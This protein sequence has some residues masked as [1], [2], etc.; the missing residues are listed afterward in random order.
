MKVSV[1]ILNWN[2]CSLLQQFLPEVVKNSTSPNVR[3]VVADN[4]STDNSVAWVKSHYPQVEVLD[5]GQN[6]GFAG[7]YNTALSL[8]DSELSV[9]LNS[10]AAP[11]P[12]WLP[13]L[14]AAM[15]QYPEAA[16]CVP[17]IKDFNKPDYFEY[18]GAAGGFIDK[19]GY[20]FCRGRMF[21]KAEKDSGQYQQPGT[22]FWGSGAALVVRTQLFV[23]SGGFDT[24]FFAHMEEIDWCWRMKNQGHQI[25]YIPESKIFHVGGGTLSYQN[26]KK[27]YLNFRNNLFLVLKNQPGF[28]AYIIIGCRY[29]LDF[30]AL[31]HFASRREW[32]NVMAVS[33]AHRQFLLQFRSFV[34]KRQ[35]LTP[36]VIKKQHPETYK[37]SVVWAFFA[38][39]KKTFS[40]LKFNPSKKL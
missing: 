22:V 11:A 33:R 27:T 40:E 36:L 20:P 9:L 7:G 1:V 8:I 25:F 15:E 32:A 31:L 28:S 23:S 34:K 30:L 26:P 16:A 29:F 18:A 14:M 4:G 19:Y 17:S 35:Q 10:D 24:D 38:K 5:L 37:G 6:M 39:G 3:I 2:T 21:D 12:N 13:P